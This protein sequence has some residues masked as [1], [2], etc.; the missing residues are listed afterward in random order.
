MIQNLTLDRMPHKIVV[1]ITITTNKSTMGI[2][3]HEM[4]V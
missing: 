1:L 4:M 2:D 3:P